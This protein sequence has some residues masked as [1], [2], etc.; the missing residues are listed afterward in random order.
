[1]EELFLSKGNGHPIPEYK[2]LVVRYSPRFG[3]PDRAYVQAG[4]KA[5]L[6]ASAEQGRMDLIHAQVGYP[7]G[8]VAMHL[9][10]EF[11]IP[12]VITEVMGPFPFPIYMEG[13]KPA[14]RILEPMRNAAKIMAISPSLQ[15]RIESFGIR[16]VTCVPGFVDERV[17]FPAA[18]DVTEPVFF[19]LSN[20]SVEKGTDD[21]IEAVRLIIQ[22]HGRAVRVRIAGPGDLN[23]YRAMANRLGVQNY[24]D[25]MGPLTRA[26]AA[27]EFRNAFA[28]VLPSRHETFGMVYAEALATGLPV[29]AARAGGPESIIDHTNGILVPVGDSAAIARAMIQVIEHRSR[30]KK[31]EI[32]DGFLRRFSRG[33]V[34]D[35][36]RKI[37]AGALKSDSGSN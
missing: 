4:R 32:R 33:V 17:F 27:Q 11:A 8:F 30:F 22:E 19:A 13:D 21:L 28:F 16:N 3:F 15:E 14:P 36:V 6:R 24:L 20:L 25:F 5:F 2:S 23:H 29:I 35:Q 10:R 12:Y 31:S 1:M 26:E 7:G 37:Y 18:H 9:A 34:V